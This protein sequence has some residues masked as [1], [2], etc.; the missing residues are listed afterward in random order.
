MTINELAKFLNHFLFNCIILTGRSE[1]TSTFF[2][3][4]KCPSCIAAKVAKMQITAALCFKSMK[5]NVSG[6]TNSSSPVTLFIVLCTATNRFWT[7]NPEM[8]L[9]ILIKA[10]M[11]IQTQSQK[12]M[13]RTGSSFTRQTTAKTISAIV[14][15]LAPSSLAV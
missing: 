12:G 1:P 13:F 11:P 7:I 10:M 9:M 14:S 5:D 3:L 4:M 6:K 2:V 8:I 15:S